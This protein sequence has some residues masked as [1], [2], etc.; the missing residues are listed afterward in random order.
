MLT[1]LVPPHI[2]CCAVVLG[3]R[4]SVAIPRTRRHMEHSLASIAVPLPTPVPVDFAISLT[5][6]SCAEADTSNLSPTSLPPPSKA[7]TTLKSPPTYESQ[8]HLVP[9]GNSYMYAYTHSNKTSRVESMSYEL[10]KDHYLTASPA[11]INL[12]RRNRNSTVKILTH[13]PT[14]YIYALRATQ[15]TQ[16]IFE[17]PVEKRE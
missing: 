12:K 15:I 3:A 13:Q 16:G 11:A 2:R 8:S 9:R 7:L 6:P 4:E 5:S 1:C 17:K 14:I 10:P